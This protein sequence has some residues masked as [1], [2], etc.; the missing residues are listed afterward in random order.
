[1]SE[2]WNVLE[3]DSRLAGP[4]PRPV[5]TVVQVV[6]IVL[7]VLGAAIV[8][9]LVAY[10]SPSGWMYGEEEVGGMLLAGA[11]A[12]PYGLHVAL[13]GPRR[14]LW[15]G[16]FLLLG[17]PT[18]L[19]LSWYLL[20]LGIGGIVAPFPWDFAAWFVEYTSGIGRPMPGGEWVPVGAEPHVMNMLLGVTAGLATGLL[21][22]TR[23]TCPSC[24]SPASNRIAGM[25]NADLGSTV[26]SRHAVHAAHALADGIEV[27]PDK[28][29]ADWLA[30]EPYPDRLEPGAEHF[31][32]RCSRCRWCKQELLDVRQ[33]PRKVSIGHIPL[34]A[35]SY[36]A[37]LPA[38]A[39]AAAARKSAGVAKVLE[40]RGGNLL[41]PIGSALPTCCPVCAEPG[42]EKT[43]L[44]F[45]KTSPG[46]VL[47]L[48]IFWPLFFMSRKVYYF[49]AH[50]CSA[51]MHHERR[52]GQAGMVI[53][54]SVLVAFTAAVFFVL[55]A[56]D[57]PGIGCLMMAM[58]PV[59]PLVLGAWW[60]WKWPKQIN[61]V[62]FTADAVLASG[63]HPDFLESQQ[64][65]SAP[66]SDVVAPTSVGVAPDSVVVD[67]G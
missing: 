5:G 34:P 29:I 12:V 51:H 44:S 10:N 23:A 66:S 43:R 19:P 8:G 26:P 56:S 4:T 16:A 62:S 42:V 49:E 52:T 47:W 65:D 13:I 1:M 40:W 60:S 46:S 36:E 45:T 63:F 54:A 31:V 2:V 55:V 39:K 25:F 17:I 32:V 64:S 20:Y 57:Y 11:A 14:S 27:D 33:H 3:S 53:I 58:V 7:G 38:V 41:I 48:F 6:L 37:L 35:K 61:Q 59:M 15:A 50:M 9:A 24:D 67:P 18:V 22:W 28:A 30:T 21:P